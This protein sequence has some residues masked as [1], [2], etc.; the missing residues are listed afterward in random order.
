MQNL[1]KKFP[2]AMSCWEIILLFIKILQN[3]SSVKLLKPL[4]L[5]D[6]GAII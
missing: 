2:Q 4:H 6:F 3:F 1:M 5:I